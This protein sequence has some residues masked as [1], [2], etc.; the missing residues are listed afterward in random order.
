MDVQELKIEGS[1]PVHVTNSPAGSPV[2]YTYAISG[3]ASG[4]GV[5]QKEFKTIVPLRIG[6]ILIVGADGP[7]EGKVT[8]IIYESDGYSPGR[9]RATLA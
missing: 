6:D 1:F 2:V 9:I 8:Q 3:V 4:H 7:K 5:T